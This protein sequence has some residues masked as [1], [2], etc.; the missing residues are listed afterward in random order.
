ML[1]I[2]AML[3]QISTKLTDENVGYIIY[4]LMSI[5]SENSLEI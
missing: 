2:Q 3:L 5:L 1:Y 4:K